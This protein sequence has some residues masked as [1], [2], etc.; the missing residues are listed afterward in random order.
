MQDF[1]CPFLKRSKKTTSEHHCEIVVS[2]FSGTETRFL[3]SRMQI[4][5]IVYQKIV[6][7]SFRCGLLIEQIVAAV[8]KIS[9]SAAVVAMI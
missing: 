7:I 1:L 3:T 4:D 8:T 6:S 5:A 9:V 2:C